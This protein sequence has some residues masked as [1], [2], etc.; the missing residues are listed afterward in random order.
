MITRGGAPHG[1]G[2]TRTLH[3]GLYV[4]SAAFLHCLTSDYISLVSFGRAELQSELKPTCR[5]SVLFGC[6]IS[7]A[8]T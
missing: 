4:S 5:I 1:Q 6:R 8:L 7:T 3:C 2:R